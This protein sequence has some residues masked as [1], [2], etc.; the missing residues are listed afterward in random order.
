MATFEERLTALEKQMAKV[1]DELGESYTLSKT[2]QQTDQILGGAVRYDEAQSLTTGEQN[3]VRSNIGAASTGFGFDATIDSGTLNTDE[4]F[5]SWF[6][7]NILPKTYR[8]PVTASVYIPYFC[9]Y[10]TQMVAFSNYGALQGGVMLLFKALDGRAFTRQVNDS[11]N[12][13]EFEYINPPMQLGVEYRTTERHLNKPVYCKTVDFGAL[14]SSSRK[15]VAHGA[16]DINRVISCTGCETNGKDVFSL[17]Q[18][19]SASSFVSCF[20]GKTAIYVDTGGNLDGWSA[21]IT[22]KYTKSTD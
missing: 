6:E 16:A 21:Y 17:P 2:G 8:K 11:G 1:T 7:A 14:P 10:R 12:W 9:N 3:R 19:T 22:I 15:S 5:K 20:A 4:A 13:S 18:Y